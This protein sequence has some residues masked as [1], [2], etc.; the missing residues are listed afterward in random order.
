M[1]CFR[2]RRKHNSGPNVEEPAPLRDD[3]ELRPTTTWRKN[4]PPAG[5]PPALAPSPAPDALGDGDESPGP[6]PG[7]LVSLPSKSSKAL[8]AAEAPENLSLIH[9]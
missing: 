4:K 5:H 9:I 3:P 1:A 2:V 7:P 8:I 6:S